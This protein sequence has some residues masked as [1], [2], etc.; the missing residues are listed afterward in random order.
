M[1]L[2][3]RNVECFSLWVIIPKH[4]GKKSCREKPDNSLSNKPMLVGII[5][6]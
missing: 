1:S 3:G 2:L 6:Q 5:L 4:Q